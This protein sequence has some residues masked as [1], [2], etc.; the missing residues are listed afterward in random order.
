MLRRVG[1]AHRQHLEHLGVLTGYRDLCAPPRVSWSPICTRWSTAVAQVSWSKIPRPSVDE[2]NYTHLPTDPTTPPN[3]GQKAPSRLGTSNSVL[4]HTVEALLSHP[5]SE[6]FL[7]KTIRQSPHLHGIL[8]N[9]KKVRDLAEASAYLQVPM[10]SVR[11]LRLAHKLGCHLKLGVYESVSFHLANA[12]RWDAVLCVV[13]LGKRQTGRASYR[14]LNWRVRA[15]IETQ[16]YSLLQGVSKEFKEHNIQPTRR[17]FH[18][19]LSGHIR[20]RNL[21]QAK[22]T[23]HEMAEAGFPADASTHAI[24]ATHYR[25]FGGDPQVQMRSL[26]A[27]HSVKSTTAAAIVNSLMQLRLDT[28]DVRGALRLLSLFDQQ[29][30]SAIF[31][32]L[33][34]VEDGEDQLTLHPFSIP[35]STRHDI[36]PTTATFSLFINYMATQSDIH[37]ALRIFY[38][39]IA[40]GFKPTSSTISSL[41]HAFFSAGQSD[42]AV[43]IT[44]SL[45]DKEKAPLTMFYPILSVPTQATLP[46]VPTGILPTIQIFNALLRGVI[47][48]YGL[49]MFD[50]VMRIMLANNITPN[51]TTLEILASHL[52]KDRRTTPAILL[53][54]LRSFR[55]PTFRPT[56]RLMHSILSSVV[57]REKALHCEIGWDATASKFSSRRQTSLRSRPEPRPTGVL[58]S[59]GPAAG[60][61]IPYNTSHRPLA[62]SLLQSL[63]ARDVKSDAPMVALRIQLDGLNGTDIEATRESFQNLL[64]RGMQPNEYHFSSLMEGLTRSGDVQGALEV[65]KSAERVGIR[66]NVVM[67][68]ILIVAHAR[69]GNPDMALRVF[70]HMVAANVKPDVPAIDA[71]T[72]AFFAV[73]AYDMA[74]RVLISLWP[75]IGPFPKELRNS[76]LKYLARLF[77]RLHLNR[78]RKGGERVSFTKDEQL[79]M[80]EKIRGLTISWKQQ[81]KERNGLTKR[82]LPN[83]SRSGRS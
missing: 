69:Q 61:A 48:A 52:S 25:S 33:S 45:C 26:E 57:R 3:I 58:N 41:I 74:K 19:V 50:V 9:L 62:N 10:R 67:F 78:G 4:P 73:G 47:H 23:L 71:V 18:L 2:E 30:V 29:A 1:L 56:L 54:F 38:S 59:I 79:A 5:G 16:H 7:L 40:H 13:A 15:L 39:M 28:H 34:S 36:H 44:A 17:T 70:Q 37:G 12:Q 53:R 76:S 63:A 75:H 8:T 46:W 11:I 27:L 82:V 43:R 68:T 31:G 77:R 55:S 20:N 22:Q 66:P 60:V 81:S 21:Q 49:E 51:H 42:V 64:I 65:M 32:E 24:V 6:K 14:L 72:S 80:H 83:F 35:T